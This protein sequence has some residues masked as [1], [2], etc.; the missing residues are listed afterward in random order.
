M[1]VVKGSLI[2]TKNR[3]IVMPNQSANMHVKIPTISLL[4]TIFTG[5]I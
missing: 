4:T 1:I 5:Y 2:N 3:S